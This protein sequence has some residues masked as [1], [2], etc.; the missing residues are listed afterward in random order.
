MTPG[1]ARPSAGTGT[2]VPAQGRRTPAVDARVRAA[3]AVL[4]GEPVAAVAA[5]HG[6]DV[7]QLLR[8]VEGL[9]SGG[10]SAVGGVGVERE[11]P[12]P[13]ATK[14]PVEDYLA[15]VAHELRTPLT[16][17]RAGLRVL[18]RDDLDAE[19]RA[20]VA[21]AVQERLDAMERLATD[22][23][24]AV[25]VATGRAVLEPEP[26]DAV[27]LLAE[28]CATVG[29]V[30]PVGAR[31]LVEV[32]ARRTRSALVALLRHAARYTGG[33][34]DLDVGLQQL[35]DA[36]LVTVRAGGVS[37]TP[38]EASGAFEPFLE[39]FSSAAAGDGNGLALYVV[40]TAVVAQGGQVGVA[41]NDDA[42]VFW[43]RLPLAATGTAPLAAARPLLEPTDS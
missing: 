4:A 28:A 26:L 40:R 32:D 11:A 9:S 22:V 7:G 31:V 36:A 25:S 5:R 19:V 29:V 12:G 15:V 23:A 6:V 41:G 2:R 3:A 27:E 34:G 8:W 33:T 35:A 30:G 14:V 43:V 24:D 16:A 18:V 10:A 37:L 17:A 38:A 1:G 13:H 42:T 20:Q 39:P 21:G